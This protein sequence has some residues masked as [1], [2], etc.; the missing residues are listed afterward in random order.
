MACSRGSIAPP[1]LSPISPESWHAG[2]WTKLLLRQ[3][4]L[5]VLNRAGLALLLVKVD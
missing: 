2:Q 1:G 3:L 5:M 4:V